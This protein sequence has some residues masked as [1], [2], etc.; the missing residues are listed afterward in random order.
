LIAKGLL[1]LSALSRV[2]CL[3]PLNILAKDIPNVVE[4]LALA[5]RPIWR[6]LPGHEVYLI[7]KVLNA[8]H[9]AADSS[10]EQID[11]MREFLALAV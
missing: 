6:S 10:R 7:E 9:A 2:F 8:E 1:R 11:R 3:A 5:I 4:V